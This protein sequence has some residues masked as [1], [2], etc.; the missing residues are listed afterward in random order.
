LSLIE[1]GHVLGLQD[2]LLVLEFG[3]LALSG[4]GDLLSFI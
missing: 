3:D 2:V 4:C 1:C